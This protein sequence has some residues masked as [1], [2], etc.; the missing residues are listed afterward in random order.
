MSS[1]GSAAA[2][3]ATE[4]THAAPPDH[5]AER[6]PVQPAIAPARTWPSCGP[7]LYD[8]TSIP[9]SRPRSSSGIVWF[10]IVD[11]PRPLSMSPAPA[12]ARQT[13]TI[14]M[15]WNHP[16]AAIAS[17]QPA[18]PPTTNSPCRRTRE[19]QPL[20]RPSAREPTDPAAYIRPRAHSASRSSARNG[21][22]AFGKAKNIAARSTAYVPSSTG[23]LH[24]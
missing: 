21:K 23:R 19:V 7:T 10:Q 14:Q 8:S 18:A 12:R 13:R 24:A 9:A 3:S 20:V 6:V 2:S 4:A 16:A 11:L 15:F 17:P 5:T 1:F 22:T